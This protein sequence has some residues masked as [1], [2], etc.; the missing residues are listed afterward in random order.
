MQCRQLIDFS[1]VLGIAF[2]VVTFFLRGCSG[3]PQM[4][5]QEEAAASRLER[6]RRDPGV[7]DGETLVPMDEPEVWPVRQRSGGDG[8]HGEGL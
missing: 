4:E 6:L 1:G 2:M 8:G 3:D 7:Q 5:A